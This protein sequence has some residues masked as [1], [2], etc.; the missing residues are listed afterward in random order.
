[1]KL[2]KLTKYLGLFALCGTANA[3]FTFTFDAGT[4]SGTA[5][6]DGD[7]VATTYTGTFADGAG[8][9]GTFSIGITDLD[10]AGTMNFNSVS[11]VAF[12]GLPNGGDGIQ[13]VIDS[14]R[15][16]QNTGGITIDFSYIV[17]AGTG[18]L[19]SAYAV[20]PSGAG[21]QDYGG[22]TLTAGGTLYD[23]GVGTGDPTYN[24]ATG[25]ITLLPNPGADGTSSEHDWSIAYSGVSSIS[26]TGGSNQVD[27]FVFGIAAAPIPEPS[28]IALLGLGGLAFFTRRKR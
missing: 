28:S 11:T 12:V 1:M 13:M 22:G 6:V 18:A 27:T 19:G 26:Y 10:A 16:N 15:A 25:A 23:L 24:E 2:Q 5:D 21:N 8:T 14:N 3:A 9:T 7:A 17:T 4:P 20:G